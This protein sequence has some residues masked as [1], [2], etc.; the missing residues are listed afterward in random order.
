V[1]LL[2]TSCVPWLHL[3][4]LLMNFH[5]LNKKKSV[6]FF[7]MSKRNFIKAQNAIK[8]TRTTTKKK[9]KTIQENHYN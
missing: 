1:Y 8:Y 2:S 5:L 9:R 6:F 4:A 7:L 3:C